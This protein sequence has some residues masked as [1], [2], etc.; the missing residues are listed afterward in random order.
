MV[1]KQTKASRL[2]AVKKKKQVQEALYDT[3]ATDDDVDST[4]LHDK[5][6]NP[7]KDAPDTQENENPDLEKEKKIDEDND[8]PIVLDRDSATNVGR[9]T[10][11]GPSVSI[12]ENSRFAID[13]NTTDER[14]GHR[15]CFQCGL[16]C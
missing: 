7:P 8:L 14:G 15:E 11:V 12:G 16:C 3:E 1:R 4:D 10:D 5:V 6:P 13:D 2:Q 9:P